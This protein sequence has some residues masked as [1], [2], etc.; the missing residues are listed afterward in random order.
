MA[1]Y[2]G[3]YS[4][5]TSSESECSGFLGIIVTGKKLVYSCY[6]RIYAISRL[7]KQLPATHGVYLLTLHLP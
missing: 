3:R 6:T 7:F 4:E 1:P 2:D 5:Q